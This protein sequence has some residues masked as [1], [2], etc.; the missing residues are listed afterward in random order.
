MI[1][2]TIEA[3]IK[4]AID[5]P[6]NINHDGSINWNYVDADTYLECRSFCRNDADFY[7]MFNEIAN[8]ID[9]VEPKDPNQLEL[10]L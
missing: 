10:N 9:P 1:Y 8:K 7:E 5:N 3:T 2:S 6:D 4:T